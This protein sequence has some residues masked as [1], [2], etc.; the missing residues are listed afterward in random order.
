VQGRASGEGIVYSTIPVENW[1]ENLPSPERVRPG[2]CSRC[3]GASRPLG[4]RLGPHGHGLRWRQ[5]RGSSA[6]GEPETVIGA[7]RR[8]LCQRYRGVTTVLPRLCARP[9]YSASA[10]GLVLCLLVLMGLAIGETRER[11]C[12]LAAGFRLESADDAS[13]VGGRQQRR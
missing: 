5:I 13:A 12:G 8:Y 10:I 7:V 4:D 1:A 11:V 2:C 6:S 3:G 9:C